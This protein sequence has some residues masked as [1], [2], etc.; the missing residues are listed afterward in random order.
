MFDRPVAR[1]SVLAFGR[2]GVFDCS[3]VHFVAWVICFV[4][5]AACAA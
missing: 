4:M 5:L 3:S 1:E 2:D